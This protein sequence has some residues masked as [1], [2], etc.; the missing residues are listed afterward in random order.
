MKALIKESDMIKI[1]TPV[2]Q[3]YIIDNDLNIYKSGGKPSRGWKFA[4]LSHVKENRF[5]SA[6]NVTPEFVA[7]NQMLYKN[8]NPCWTIRDIDHGTT[9]EWGNTTKHGVKYIR[10]D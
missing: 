9:R 1:T 2:L 10:F 8:G 5:V 3:E 4:G 7:K 6:E